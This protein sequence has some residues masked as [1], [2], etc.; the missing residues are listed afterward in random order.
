MWSALHVECAVWGA[1]CGCKLCG[2]KLCGACYM[3]GVLLPSTG[4]RE[5]G[6]RGDA[7]AARTCSKTQEQLRPARMSA[8]AH[9]RAHA[10]TSRHAH[11]RMHARGCTYTNAFIHM[12]ARICTW[13]PS[14]TRPRAHPPTAAPGCTPRAAL[15][16]AY[17]PPPP[18]AP[19]PVRGPFLALPL[20]GLPS[21]TEEEQAT[22]T[23]PANGVHAPGPVSGV[24]CAAAARSSG[25]RGEE[26]TQ[27][28]ADDE[29]ASSAD[30]AAAAL[31]PLPDAK[32][33]CLG[34]TQ[35]TAA[36][37]AAAAAGATAA[38]VA[39]PSALPVAGGV[40]AV[41]EVPRNASMPM[42]AGSTLESCSAALEAQAK[43]MADA[44][45][46]GVRG[47]ADAEA[48]CAGAVQ[49]HA[50]AY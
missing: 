39:A 34:S 44:G 42:L 32:A 43:G 1:L 30:D 8:R 48:T 23:A 41:G 18:S 26:D 7:Y 50:L 35:T 9:T 36:A 6:G 5:G 45:T 37:A 19:T 2:C 49:G 16:L 25:T 10:R 46:E 38:E 24:A 29:V 28:G 22:T 31:V 33:S 12:R 27:G 4:S 3:L 47:V 15:L 17:I 13:T 20:Q 14:H 11:M 21:Y 40:A